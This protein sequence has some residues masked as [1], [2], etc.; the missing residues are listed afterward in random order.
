[1]LLD[2]MILG[3]SLFFLADL[4]YLFIVTLKSLSGICSMPTSKTRSL[5]Y[6]S[7]FCTL[8]HASIK[9][10]FSRMKGEQSVLRELVKIWCSELLPSDLAQQRDSGAE[11]SHGR[12]KG[13]G[14]SKGTIA[15]QTFGL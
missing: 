11:H 10:F 3:V 8:L 4:H 9:C 1:M 7:D 2:S 12:A 5:S 15:L 13:T 14:C 6:A